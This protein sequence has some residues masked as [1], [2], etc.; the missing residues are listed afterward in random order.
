MLLTISSTIFK[1]SV[2]QFFSK[3]FIVLLYGCIY[4]YFIVLLYGCEV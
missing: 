3:T 2:A 1:L 4:N